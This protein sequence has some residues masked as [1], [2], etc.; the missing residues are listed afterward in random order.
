VRFLVSSYSDNGQ[1]A[2]RLRSD[3]NGGDSGDGIFAPT[4]IGAG[5]SYVATFYLN[6]H[7][8]FL[9]PGT[10]DVSCLLSL[11]T[12]TVPE[13]ATDA[14]RDPRKAEHS[15]LLR[16]VVNDKDEGR[17]RA[18]I[19]ELEKELGSDDATRRTEAAEAILFLDNPQTVPALK[20]VL[21]L[22][23]H[24]VDAVRALGRIGTQQALDL[25]R[26][27]LSP[28]SEAH[29]VAAAL[30]ALALRGCVPRDK[31]ESLLNSD[32]ARLRFVVVTYLERF[33]NRED[34]SML[35]GVLAD[36][37]PQVAQAARKCYEALIGE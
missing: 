17:V 15:S 4:I 37:D 31:I 34:A 6:R 32:N 5:E 28:K 30:E 35:R 25:I 33:G 10:Y 8:S 14:P 23:N 20:K 12:W 9:S 22:R 26:S 29:V 21:A 36:G 2:L 13:H 7:V 16:I 24:E 19:D 27:V 18:R 3:Q 1:E 11:T